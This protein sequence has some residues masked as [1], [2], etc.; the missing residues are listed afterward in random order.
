M[1]CAG[2]SGII[3]TILEKVPEE[4]EEKETKDMRRFLLGTFTAL[5]SLTLVIAAA[6]LFSRLEKS[7]TP[8]EQTLQ[9]TAVPETT[10]PPVTEKTQ[11]PQE[12]EP[13]QTSGYTAVPQY[14]QTD[15]P[16]VK[17]GNGTI[18]TSGCSITCLAMVATYLTDHEYLPDQLAY[19]FG[20]YG[21]NNIERLDNAIAEMWLPKER[22]SNVVEVLQALKEGKVAIAMMDDESVFTTTQ[23]FIVI[24]GMTEDGK[25]I[26]HDPIEDH[27]TADVYMEEHFANGFEDYDLMRG[28]SGAWVFDK[29]AMPEEPFLYDAAIPEQEENRYEGYV[30]E[31]DDIYMLAC[32]AWAEGRD[33]TPEIQQAMLEVVLNRVVSDQFPNTV[34]SVIYSGELSRAKQQMQKAT[35]TMEQYMA[36]TAAMYGPYILPEGVHYYEQWNTRGEA[37]GELGDYTFLYT[38]TY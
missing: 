35:P 34:K 7:D 4:K 13:V 38:R 26:V 15:Y 22:M 16:Y 3:K 1:H 17:Y 18:S 31:E 19:H 2:T 33:E 5:L 9:T 30:M 12:T 21:K 23:H 6:F 14:F 8:K 28:F 36:V 32:F 11:P 27:Y 29:S 25:Y 10:Q 20:D 24:A 37:W